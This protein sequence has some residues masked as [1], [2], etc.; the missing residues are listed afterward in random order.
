[1]RSLMVA[2][3]LAAAVV[4]AHAEERELVTADNA[5]LCLSP[6]ALGDANRPAIAKSQDRLRG[7]RCLRSG[8]GIPIT[9]L[10]DAKTDGPW[11][12]RFRPQGISGGVTLW[13]LPSSFAMP[14]GSKVI[15]SAERAER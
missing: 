4:A 7:L 5:I 14:D 11:M 1:M 9:V 10:E 15:R 2:T 6:E 13:G 12:I 8:S 3:A